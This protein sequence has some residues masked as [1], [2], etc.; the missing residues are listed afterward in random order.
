MGRDLARA[1]RESAEA[2]SSAARRETALKSSG[3]AWVAVPGVGREGVC[4]ERRAMSS[5]R[6][7]SWSQWAPAGWE[8][9]AVDW[10]AGVSGGLVGELLQD[11]RVVERRARVVRA[12]KWRTRVGLVFIGVL[13][14][15]GGLWG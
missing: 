1:G 9:G 12:V 7:R 10:T 5:R 8:V 4:W 14:W 11:G 13:G 15:N 3:V 2:A 6:C